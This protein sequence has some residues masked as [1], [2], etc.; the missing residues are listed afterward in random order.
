MERKVALSL[1][2]VHNG[3]GRLKIIWNLIQ[4]NSE[5]NYE[6]LSAE[7]RALNTHTHTHWTLYFYGEKIQAFSLL[8][9]F[10]VTVELEFIH[11][12]PLAA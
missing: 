5:D 12:N 1:V 2:M 7:K 10:K 6:F 8:Y 9:G 3:T 4:E 11:Y